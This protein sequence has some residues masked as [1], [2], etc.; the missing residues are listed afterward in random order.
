MLKYLRCDFDGLELGQF[1]ILQGQ[2]S[3]CQ[4]KAHRWFPI[5]I[6]S[7]NF[8]HTFRRKTISNASDIL[9]RTYQ[10]QGALTVAHKNIKNHNK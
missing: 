4:L 9:N 10:A 7:F 6:R 1:K 2:M 5:F 3:W 8:V